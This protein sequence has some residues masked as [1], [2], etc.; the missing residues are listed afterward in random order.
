MCFASAWHQQRVVAVLVAS[1]LLTPAIV[2]SS[3]PPTDRV[4]RWQQDL[5]FLAEELPKKHKNLFATLPEDEFRQALANLE[6]DLPQLSDDDVH[7]RLMQL[8]VRVRDAHTAVAPGNLLSPI[9]PVGLVWL[10]DGYYATRV[11]SAYAAILGY[12][13]TAVQGMPI[14]QVVERVQSV[15]P[16]END[17]WLREQLPN[18]LI[19]PKVLKALGI[20]SESGKTL[21]TFMD[22]K[23]QAHEVDVT[24]KTLP[25]VTKWSLL[26]SP[27]P[28]QVPLRYQERGKNYWHRWL[29]DHRQL[30]ICYHACVSMPAAPIGPWIQEVIA[31]LDRERPDSVV[32][33][34]RDNTGGASALLE[35]LIRAIG[36]RDWLNHSG[37]VWVLIGR[38]TFSSAFMNA[39]Q[40]K[41]A[42]KATLV[43]EP[44]G[45]KPNS[46]GEVKMLK[47]PHSGL[48][49]Q[50]STQYFR[51]YP[52]G[53]P[54]TFEPDVRLDPTLDDVRTGRDRALEYTRQRR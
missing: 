30:Y 4:A 3:A 48:V 19:A 49:V 32:I 22:A 40:F 18:Y 21:L 50:Y 13:L 37:R 1:M 26:F 39:M 9:L 51:R 20:I 41:Q 34:L 54:L 47:L 38:R 46:F 45:Q 29:P 24:P 5:K 42:T 33:D 16:H 15:V 44:T 35:P 52:Q 17:W 6:R 27:T 43:G 2:L 14:D 10:S 7:V 12:K 53:D 31:L 23:G 28:D 36:E 25:E 8:A 11:D